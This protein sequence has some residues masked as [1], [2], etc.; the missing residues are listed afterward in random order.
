VDQFLGGQVDHFPAGGST[1]PQIAL[2]YGPKGEPEWLIVLGRD[3][4]PIRFLLKTGDAASLARYRLES[5][6]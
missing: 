4:S 3:G 1:D 6:W 2:N 5:S